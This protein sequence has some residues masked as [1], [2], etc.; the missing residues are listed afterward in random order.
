MSSGGKAHPHDL[1]EE[2]PNDLLRE[3]RLVLRALFDVVCEVAALRN[4]HNDAEPVAVKKGLVVAHN[5]GVLHRR[6]QA[7]LICSV[8]ALCRVHLGH[9]RLFDG[10]RVAVIKTIHQ[11]DRAIATLAQ[12][13]EDLNNLKPAYN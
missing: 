1:N 8:L 11:V 10:V 7:D 5:I 4:L 6:Q 2:R 13:L 12:K 3:R 9:I